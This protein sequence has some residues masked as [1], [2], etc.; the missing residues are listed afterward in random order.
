ML[1]ILAHAIIIAA[2]IL[3]IAS[4]VH[5]IRTTA[6]AVCKLLRQAKGE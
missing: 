1:N 5:T 2:G 4:I 6:P 3:A